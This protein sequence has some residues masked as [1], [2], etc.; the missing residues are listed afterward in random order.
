[1][2][3]VA[4][5]QQQEEH[6]EDDFAPRDGVGGGAV[7]G[8]VGL[9]GERVDDAADDGQR[10]HPAEQELDR[11]AP[12]RLRRELDDLQRQ[13]RALTAPTTGAADLAAVRARRTSLSKQISR[14]EK[15]LEE[16]LDLLRAPTDDVAVLRAAG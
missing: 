1:M 10:H 5:G 3:P 13:Q 4:C 15:A 12:A 8:G 7:G 9:I 2:S 14:A 6:A 11:Q 16:A